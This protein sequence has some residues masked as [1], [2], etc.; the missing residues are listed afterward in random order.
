M[1]NCKSWIDLSLQE[2]IEMV[3]K[4]THLMQNSNVGFKAI[5]EILASAETV[6]IFK[7]VII[8][9]TTDEKENY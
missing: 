8:N 4:T 9:P 3:G 2:K 6:G 5:F 1:A 7:E